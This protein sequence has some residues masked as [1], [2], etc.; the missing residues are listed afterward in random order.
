M[1]SKSKKLVNCVEKDCY[2]QNI[3]QPVFVQSNVSFQT[4]FVLTV[5][6][7]T[8]LFVNQNI[9]PIANGVK[10]IDLFPSTR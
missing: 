2:F 6:S 3:S 10:K 7:K 5:C 9:F 4:K 8:E 1:I